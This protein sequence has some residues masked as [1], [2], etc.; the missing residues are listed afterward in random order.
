MVLEVQM[1]YDYVELQDDNG[2]VC[3]VN[4]ANITAVKVGRYRGQFDVAIFVNGKEDHI[5][6]SRMMTQEEAYDLAK[7]ITDE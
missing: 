5:I 6:K 4:R 2:E 3:F 7:S 1:K